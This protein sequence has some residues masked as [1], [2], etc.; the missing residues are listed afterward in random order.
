MPSI[1][2]VVVH[3]SRLAREGLKAILANSPFSPVCITSSPDEVP[4]TIASASEQVLVLMGVRE[5]AD[6]AQAVSAAKASFP[7]APVVVIGDSGRHDLV[8]TALA[9]GAATF[10]DEN[11]ATSA[12]I[13]ELE[14]VA[15][16]H[17]VIS[18]VL[19]NRLLAQGPAL[20]LE[21]A[22]A[23]ILLV[24]RQSPEDED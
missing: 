17:P 21:Q 22:I 7:D 10:I 5:T 23:P 15:Q 6:L 4:S 19:L 12:L 8:M 14:L 13:K 18:V 20:N 1:V 24:Q 3:P 2:C 9:L 16:G 11:L